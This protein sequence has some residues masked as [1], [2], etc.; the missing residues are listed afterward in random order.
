MPD[1]ITD[2]GL[3][4]SENVFQEPIAHKSH[5]GSDS[6]YQ[7]RIAYSVKIFRT[8]IR[9]AGIV[10]LLVQIVKAFMS[11]A[12]AGNIRLSI[13]VGLIVGALFVVVSLPPFLERAIAHVASQLQ[14]S[15]FR[16]GLYLFPFLL[17]ALVLWAKIKIGPTSDEWRHVSSEGSLSEY[18]TAVAYLLIPIFAYPML[19]QFKRQGKRLMASLYALFIAGAVFIGMEEISWG[20]RILGFQEPQFWTD[21]NVQSEFTFHNFAFF[22]NN[23]LHLSFVIAGFI[24]SFC[25]LGLRYWQKRQHASRTDTSQLAP[26][27]EPTYLLPDWPLSSFFYPTLIFY[28]L[29]EFTDIAQRFNFL[30]SA[31][32]EHW[33]FIM[34]LGVLMFVVINFFRQGQE[35]DRMRQDLR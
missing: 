4:P 3:P 19:K 9:L 32:Q 6:C 18:G 11:L 23:L 30:H 25:W 14:R 27:L 22:Q 15:R 8:T 10:Q 28:S 13:I 5:S 31:D 26:K 12:E 7:Q 2:S 16:T 29:L 21:H 17:S 24:G 20:Q 34:S 35:R 1:Q 33:E